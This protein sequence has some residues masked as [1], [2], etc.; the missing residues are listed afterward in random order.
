M[1]TMNEEIVA[2]AEN[3][4]MGKERMR[5]A[6]LAESPAARAPGRTCKALLSAAA[7]L[8]LVFAAVFAIPAARAE[9][10]S[11]F[12]VAASTPAEY[13]DGEPEERVPVAALDELIVQPMGSDNAGEVGSATDNRILSVADEP[14]W[15]SIAND[16][17]VGLGETLVDGEKMY[18]TLKLNGLTAL[19]I[20]D[21]ITGGSAT[22]SLIPAE[23]LPSIFPDGVPAEY[24]DGS[25]K[26]LEAADTE[27]LLV[28]EDG[29]T[30]EL[31]AE[32]TRIAF[33]GLFDRM[34]DE[35]GV[36][37]D[38]D[39]DDTIREQLSAMNMDWLCG[40]TVPLTVSCDLWVWEY[41][42][43]HADD[44]VE[45]L[46]RCADENGMLRAK[47]VCRMVNYY[48]QPETKLE[49]ELGEACFDVRTFLGFDSTPLTVKANE[50][51]LGHNEVILSCE[52][53]NE[54]GGFSVTNIEADLEGVRL[55][56]ETAYV[57]ALGLR[58]A[59]FSVAFPEDWTDDMCRAF[60]FGLGFKAEVDGTAYSVT[61]FGREQTGEREYRIEFGMMHL[62]YDSI[63]STYEL[64]IV[65]ELTYSAAM[66]RNEMTRVELKVGETVTRPKRF[67]HFEQSRPIELSDAELV[68]T[69]GE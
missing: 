19:P 2:Y 34:N 5:R 16:F 45:F 3:E 4:L 8:A 12:G 50:I 53:W 57:N 30:A 49:A 18:L 33:S 63:E 24:A 20:A 68:F 47:V 6:V 52:N 61:S 38:P 36:R 23:L 21:A 17:S 32:N 14:I 65:P 66:W 22:R 10:L 29:T 28:L 48:P 41:E 64:R 9:V 54:G 46:S 31:L 62:P 15:Q 51:V 43:E 1:K 59:A 44:P 58:G 69:V 37:V 67:S 39:C 25:V 13:L 11:W 35:F 55:I 42:N 26:F 40:R 7:C 56:P 60:V 27:I